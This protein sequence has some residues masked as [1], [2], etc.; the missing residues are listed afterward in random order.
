MADI[1]LNLQCTGL[2]QPHQSNQLDKKP[3][4]LDQ[5]VQQDIQFRNRVIGKD[6]KGSESIIQEL[7]E[8]YH[9]G[10]RVTHSN[11]GGYQLFYKEGPKIWMRSFRV[12]DDP[13]KGEV[14]KNGQNSTFNTLDKFISD[15][16]HAWLKNHTPI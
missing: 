4:R 16:S 9:I 7:Q 1:A 6:A 10:Y 8:G 11:D 3:G 15:T 12:I 5:L 13:G 2:Y 14:L